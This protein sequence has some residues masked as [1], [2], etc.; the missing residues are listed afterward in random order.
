MPELAFT[1]VERDGVRVKVYEAGDADG[2]GWDA[3][4]D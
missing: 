4:W 2:Y 3:D 1:V